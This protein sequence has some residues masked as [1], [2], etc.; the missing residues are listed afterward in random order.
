MASDSPV[1][2]QSKKAKRTLHGWQDQFQAEAE[3]R[4]ALISRAVIVIRLHG[5]Q[6]NSV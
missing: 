4:V 3:L 2:R 1:W 5:I 6:Q